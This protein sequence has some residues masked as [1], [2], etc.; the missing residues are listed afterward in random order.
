MIIRQ[1]VNVTQKFFSCENFS[2]WS[3]RIA[4]SFANKNVSEKKENCIRVSRFQWS[5]V[6]KV[7]M[8]GVLLVVQ[9]FLYIINNPW[10]E[11]LTSKMLARDTSTMYKIHQSTFQEKLG[12]GGRWLATLLPW[13][14][15]KIAVSWTWGMG[16][17][18]N[19][20]LD[21]IMGLRYP[22]QNSIRQ[23]SSRLGANISN[24]A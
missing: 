16:E 21:Q 24:G 15:W 2:I 9:R 12:G 11:K 19:M 6:P 8:E 14:E 13:R 1:N 23:L 7:C 22:P 10:S 17:V 4:P 20:L 3:V 5:P 18:C